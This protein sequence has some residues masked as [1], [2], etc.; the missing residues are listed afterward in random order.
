MQSTDTIT[1]LK[2]IHSHIEQ[3][4]L[5]QTIEGVKALASMSQQW[6]IT[7]KI[8]ELETNYQYML[9]Y[10]IEGKKDPEQQHIYE[11]LI[12][13]LYM[14]ADD[15]AEHLLLQESSALFFERSRQ[16]QVRLPLSMDEYRSIITRQAD[17]FS[18]ISLLEEGEE[19]DRRLKENELTHENTLQDLFYSLFV[20][21]RANTDLIA[22]YRAFMD[23]D[24]IPVYDKSV[25]LSALTMNLLQRFDAAKVELLLDVC[26]RPDPELATRAII[27]I[28]P[29][30]QTYTARWSLY[31]EC[32]NRL[33]LLSDDKL[34]NRRFVAA[35]IGFIQAHETEKITKRL[36]EEILPEM[37]KLSPMI[38]K[39]INLDEWMGESGLDEKNPEW[40]KIL[41]ESG[42]T[43]KLQEFSE[44]QL[45]GADVFHSTFSNLKS[46]P[47]FQEMSN[48]FLPFNPRHSSIR[49]LFSDKSEGASLIETMLRSSLICNSDKYSFCFSVMMMPE[50]YRRMMIT[51]LGAEGEELT[52]MQAEEEVL[53]PYQKEDTLIKQ[54]IQDLYRFFKLYK[55][56]TGFGDIFGLPLNYHLI[57]AFHPVVLQ[58]RHLEQI[59]LYYFEKNNFSEAL[60]AYMML[61][62]T[63]VTKS[64]VWQKIGYC[65]QMLADIGGA[66]EAYL[67]ADLIDENNTW[68]IH[69]IAH[70]YRMLKQPETALIYYRRLEQFRPDDLQIQLNIGHCYLELK[71]YDT[72]LNFYFKVELLDSRNRRAWR[73]VAWCAFL[74]RKFD[75][76]QKYYALILENEPNAHDYLN[77]GHV[78]LCLEE[79]KKA[80]QFYQTS[81]EKAGSFDAFRSMLTED[82]DELQEAGV[83]TAL[84]PIILDKIRY[85]IG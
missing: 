44:L 63:G 75:V 46:Y 61:A 4:D 14:V 15:A 59:A 56:S 21:P 58:P 48:W 82:E 26:G 49:Q 38:G 50:N 74:S 9:H 83:N 81:M 32:G 73:S 43:D 1:K 51:Q 67:H 55:R 41:D 72:A 22:S 84:L 66:L 77:A 13:D 40:Q 12:R 10:L 23:D 45:E 64:E 68:V 65:R 69:R 31:P 28:I 37:M 39:K 54:Y 25:F 80:V 70:C 33:K 17:T 19:K 2:V 85:E 42:L 57:E 11:K 47:F 53:K 27:G 18:F 8:S 24:L 3:R 62:E 78:E 36:T 20:S 76:A 5:K 79:N 30:F 35:I 60:T 7:E 52:K 34:F 71:Q 16:Q 6:A 29:I